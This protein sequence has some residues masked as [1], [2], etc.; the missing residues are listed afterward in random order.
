MIFILRLARLAAVSPLLVA[1]SAP[2]TTADAAAPVDATTKQILI[3]EYGDS[4]T[5]GY[6]ATPSGTIIAAMNQPNTLQRLLRTEYGDRVVVKNEGI[7]GIQSSDALNGTDGIHQSWESVMAKSHA[8]IVTLNFGLGDAYLFSRPESGKISASPQEYKR[9]MGELVRI[10]REHGKTVV[11][12]EPNPS[13]HPARET[14]MP[15]YVMHLDQLGHEMNI[16]MASQFWALLATPNWRELLSDC[17]HPTPELYQL[18]GEN[19]Y[20]VLRPI[21]KQIIDAS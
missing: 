15:Y 6:T 10:A 20:K 21:V 2:V 13:C 1:C 3:E 14:G 19:A 5:V 17:T 18:K 8:Q 16:P 4:T 7:G 9:V 12:Y 11:I